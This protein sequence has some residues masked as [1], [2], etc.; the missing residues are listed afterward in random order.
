M[1]STVQNWFS[2][3]CSP[4]LIEESRGRWSIGLQCMHANRHPSIIPSVPQLR[5]RLSL[6][7][8]VVAAGDPIPGYNFPAARAG[9]TLNYCQPGCFVRRRWAGE[10]YVPAVRARELVGGSRCATDGGSKPRR[11]RSVEGPELVGRGSII[12]HR[13]AGLTGATWRHRGSASREPMPSL[14]FCLTAEPLVS[15]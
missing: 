2:R 14:W 6:G 1:A 4:L 10:G 5:L 7:S 12:G 11:H 8:A 15:S 3:A 9:A 13:N